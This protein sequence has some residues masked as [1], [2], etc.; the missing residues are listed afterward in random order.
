M[1]R[2]V[3]LWV[4]PILNAAALLL[5]GLDKLMAVRQGRRIREFIL[6]IAA[7]A[8]ALGA[9][10]GMVAF[11]HKTSKVK[12]RTMVPLCALLHAALT[13]WLIRLI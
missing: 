6:L 9:L 1:A 13:L 5:Y 11:H 4:L 3:L 8:G 12:F 10:A 2:I 7:L